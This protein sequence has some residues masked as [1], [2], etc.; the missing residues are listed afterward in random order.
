MTK[1]GALKQTLRQLIIGLPDAHFININLNWSNFAYAI[2]YPQKH[3]KETKERIANLGPYLHKAYGDD[4]LTS[5]D[6]DMQQLIKETTWDEKQ[7][8]HNQS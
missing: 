4:I 7:V 1:N 2:V 5:F 6:A 3:E 8:D